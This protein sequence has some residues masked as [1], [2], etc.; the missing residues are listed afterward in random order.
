MTPSLLRP[1]STTTSLPTRPTTRPFRMAPL[2]KLPRVVSM[3]VARASSVVWPSI[4]AASSFWKPSSF[5]SSELI[6]L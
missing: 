1:T 6:R 5:T 3:V 2:V 4:T